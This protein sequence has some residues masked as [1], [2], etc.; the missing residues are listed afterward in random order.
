MVHDGRRCWSTQPSSHDSH[1][2]IFMNLHV[3]LTR[4]ADNIDGVFASCPVSRPVHCGHR[5][6]ARKRAHDAVVRAADARQSQGDRLDTARRR[7]F[8]ASDRGLADQVS[9][10]GP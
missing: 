9:G 3:A 7:A 5:A 10:G 4:S 8:G 2:M 1:L 6:I